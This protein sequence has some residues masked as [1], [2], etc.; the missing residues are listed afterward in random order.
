MSATLINNRDVIVVG[1]GPAGISA[2]LSLR[3]LNPAL[4]SEVL[5]LEKAVHPRPKLCGGGVTALA[6]EILEFLEIKSRV[7][8][9]PIHKVQFRFSNKPVYFERPNL[10]RI[11][12][13]EQFDADLVRHA[14]L[15]GIEIKE[16]QEVTDLLREGDRIRVKTKN[17]DYL[18]RVLVGADGAKSLVRRKLVPANI[19]RMSRLLEVVIKA[20]PTEPAFTEN[21]AILDFRHLDKQLQG[22]LWDFPTLVNGEP[23]LNVGIFDSRIHNSKRAKLKP[24]LF[25]KLALQGHSANNVKLLGHPERWFV[26]T[27]TYSAKN[28]ILVGDAAGIE[29]WLGEGISIALAYGPVSAEAIDAAFASN[30]FT[31]SDYLQRIQENRLGQLLNRNRKLARCFYARA[32]RP[33]VQTFARGLEMYFKF[34][35]G[36]S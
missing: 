23:H 31:F 32:A 21:M 3:K 6:E 1:S 8:G 5:V 24:L 30:D 26:P 13:R 2:A 35:Q 15:A 14:R 33:F 9:F 22:Y 4:A 36:N 29:P 18:T 27:G 17:G 16:N 7:A 12:R 28:V 20:E 19:S 25:D 34:S 10:M 11:V